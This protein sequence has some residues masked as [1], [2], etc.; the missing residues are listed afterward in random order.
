[1][2]SFN[3]I[4][5][6]FIRKYPNNNEY[7]DRINRELNL[8]IKKN[9]IDYILRICEILI[10]CNNIPHIIRGSSGSSLICYLLGITDIDPIKEKIAFSRFLNEY[11]RSMPDIDMDFP[12]N[13]RKYVFEKIFNKWNNV[14]RISNHVTYGTKGAT[15]KALKLMGV[16]GKVP[17]D[18][19]NINYFKDPDKKKELEK[20]IKDLKGTLKNF[21]LHCGGIIFYNDENLINKDLLNDRQIKWNKNEV[22]NKGYFKI[23]ILANRGL[24]QLFD[25]DDKPLLNYD[26]ND[27]KTINL[28]HSGDNFGITFAESPAMRKVL[29]LYK[30]STVQDIAK[31]LAIIRPGAK[32]EDNYSLEDNPKNNKDVNDDIDNDDIYIEDKIDGNIIFDD[33]AIYYIMSLIGCD[34]NK[35]DSIRRLYAKNNKEGINEFEFDLCAKYPDLD[36]NDIS[37]KLTNLKK[38]S[39]CK[40]HALSYAYLVYGLAYQ[41]ANNPKEFWKSTIK[42]C[43]SMYRDWVHIREGINN[44]LK[45]KGEEELDNI[46]HFYKY[47]YWIS[48]EFIDKNMYVDITENKKFKCVFRGLIASS[49]FYKKY[50]TNKKKYDYVTFITIGYKNSVFIDIVVKKWISTKGKNI[51]S[52]SGTIII[53]NNDYAIINVDKYILA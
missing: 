13:Q 9:F 43:N 34:E 31:C 20:N 29:T 52:G 38:Y 22:D 16:E 47:G 36:V 25:I 40:S 21:S 33:D 46:K 1:M 10:L 44:G 27:K 15:R 17:K 32:T 35:A 42:N 53:K 41:K 49:K 3:I 6:K 4:K 24:T 11:R 26:F 2:D 45:I 5:N 19:C 37:N 18:K 23:D 48:K 12:H 8:I 30:P 7:N 51:C 14:V 50:N 39:F 28:L